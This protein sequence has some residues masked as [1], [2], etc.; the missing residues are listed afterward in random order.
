MKWRIYDIGIRDY[1][2][3]CCVSIDDYLSGKGCP[4]GKP[5]GEDFKEARACYA[6]ATNGGNQLRDGVWVFWDWRGDCAGFIFKED[7]NGTTYMV[8]SVLDVDTE[9]QDGYGFAPRQLFGER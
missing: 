4:F 6:S 2:E 3:M 7:N 9:N 8:V 5:D 1:H